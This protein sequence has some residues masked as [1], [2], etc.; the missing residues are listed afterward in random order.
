MLSKATYI[1]SALL[2]T[3]LAAPQSV[4]EKPSPRCNPTDAQG[5]K[6][7]GEI[8]YYSDSKCSQRIQGICHYGPQSLIDGATS[9]WGCGGQNF[10]EKAPFYAKVD[11]S[12]FD[13]IQFAFTNDQKCP[14]E[15][16]GAIF[17]TLVDNGKCVLIN[18]GGVVPGT[19]IYPKGGAPFS[20][21][22]LKLDSTASS[23]PVS[24]DQKRQERG[25][26]CQGWTLH[27]DHMKPTRTG[28]EQA[29]DIL[30]CTNG[31]AGGCERTVSVKE[32]KPVRTRYTAEPPIEGAFNIE[33]VFGLDYTDSS[34]SEKPVTL[35]VPQGQ[36]GYLAVSSEATLFD[37]GY[38]LGCNAE[39]QKRKG[40]GL[41]VKKNAL[42]YN[43]VLTSNTDTGK[44]VG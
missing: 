20:R 15:G 42:R 24:A 39:P 2:G 34:T 30:D 31:P 28:T 5:Q 22:Q 32:L 8:G 9:S 29:S 3:A 4:P 25:V 11:D 38:Y 17:A 7:L 33:S 14:P 27:P 6:F 12:P 41:A 43:V 13:D 10:P 37:E 36:A 16:P 40:S 44:S 18:Y 35:S 19:T 23:V 26:K 21:A 1:T